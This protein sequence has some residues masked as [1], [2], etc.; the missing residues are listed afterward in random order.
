[1]EIVNCL[2]FKDSF[3]ACE[4]CEITYRYEVLYK[5]VHECSFPKFLALLFLDQFMETLAV[6]LTRNPMVLLPLK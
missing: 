3:K 1:M 5:K 2:I 6:T 4:A